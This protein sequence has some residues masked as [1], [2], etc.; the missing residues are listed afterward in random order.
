METAQVGN[1]FMWCL[2]NVNQRH[3]DRLIELYTRQLSIQCS[4][5]NLIVNLI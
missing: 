2:V 5:I 1:G 4:L 3:S